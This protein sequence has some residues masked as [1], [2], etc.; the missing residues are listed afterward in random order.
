[1]QGTM[2]L[3]FGSLF[4]FAPRSITIKVMKLT[5]FWDATQRFLVELGDGSL[6]Y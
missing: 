5:V 3:K 1:M 2:S 6:Y 4:V